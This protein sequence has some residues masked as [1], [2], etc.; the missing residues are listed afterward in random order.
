MV[1]QIHAS[2]LHLGEKYFFPPNWENNSAFFSYFQPAIHLFMRMIPRKIDPFAFWQAISLAWL[3]LPVQTSFAQSDSLWTIW[4]DETRHDSLRLKAIE[5]YTYVAFKQSGSDSAFVLAQLAY[6]FAAARGNEKYMGVARNIQGSAMADKN[7]YTQALAYYELAR[8]HFEKIGYSKGL[9]GSWYNT[10]HAYTGLGESDTAASLYLYCA[11]LFE[12]TENRKTRASSIGNAASS[13]IDM[14]NYAKALV[15]TQ[16]ALVLY[17]ENGDQQGLANSYTRLGIIYHRQ[18][19]PVKAQEYYLQSLD[20]T[21]KTGNKRSEAGA[22][23]NLGSFYLEQGDETGAIAWFQRGR[24]IYEGLNVPAGMAMAYIHIGIIKMDNRDYDSATWYY[25]QALEL[26]TKSNNQSGVAHALNNLAS[27][28][29]FKKEFDLAAQYGLEAYAISSKLNIPS[30]AIFAAQLLMKTYSRSGDPA[31]ALV[32]LSALKAIAERQLMDNYFTLTE[33]EKELYFATMDDDFGNYFDFTLIYQEQFPA[34]TDTAYN[35]ALRNKG[36]TLRSSTAL[37]FSILNSG[38]TILISDYKKWLD[39]RQQITNEFA[40]GADT[41]DLENL[42]NGLEKQLVQRSAVFSDF[43]K[44]RNLDWKQ[45]RANLREGECA[46]EFVNFDSQLDTTYPDIYAALLVRSG[47]EHPAMVKLCTADDLAKILGS[48]QGNNAAFVNAVYGS[49]REANTALYQLIWRPLESYLEEIQTVYYSPSGL[50]HKVAFGALSKSQDVYL[51]DLYRFRQL[52]STGVL[53]QGED[54]TLQQD[55]KF[56]LM[57]GVE[58][59]GTN[60]QQQIWSYLPGSLDETNRINQFLRKKKYDVN[61][62]SS[63]LA[64]EQSFKKEVGHHTIIHIATHGFFFPD[65]DELRN[66]IIDHSET[67]KELVFRGTTNYA[68]WNFVTNKNPLMRSGIVLAGANDAWSRNPLQTG[69]DGILTAQ[70]V[71]T[72]DLRNTRLVVLS[73]CE[74][75]LGDIKGSEGVFG[76]QRAFKIAGAKYLIMS[77]WQVP[78]KETSEFMQLFYKNLLKL[79]DIP[80][81][82]QRTQK[83]IRQKY[84]PYYWGAF[85]LIE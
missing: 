62:L 26:N 40:K 68:N 77:L 46:I 42:A 4:Q 7:D 34:L 82:F 41:R 69:E 79:K 21:V 12:Q 29:L 43:D 72:L 74:T 49:R 50:L 13:F 65:P 64:T 32:Y 17:Q 10:A 61:Y 35:I 73:A 25:N 16:Q 59:N 38:D 18:G 52:S 2:H 45:V 39:L 67:Q 36:L 83:I 31:K 76:L 78:D 24:K 57:G 8:N 19:D 71:A 54:L 1:A 33:H 63:T 56:L 3:L 84:D 27:V 30:R 28:H 22:C 58:Y 37:R 60:A 55:E 53:A 70:E 85:V 44:V 66:S 80:L 51:S 5:A 15:Y 11:T 20:L 9:A 6:D 81:A 47:D 23:I 14:G 48:F 75:G